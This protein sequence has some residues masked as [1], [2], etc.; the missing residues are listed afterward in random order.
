MQYYKEKSP[1]LKAKVCV[2][3]VAIVAIIAIVAIVAIVAILNSYS[4]TN[5]S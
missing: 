2:A 3:I 4:V 5:P 1:I